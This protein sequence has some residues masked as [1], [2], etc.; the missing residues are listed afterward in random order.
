MFIKIFIHGKRD[1]I[2]RRGDHILKL[3]IGENVDS[4]PYELEQSNVEDTIEPKSKIVCT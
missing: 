4:T 3:H 1:F 2:I